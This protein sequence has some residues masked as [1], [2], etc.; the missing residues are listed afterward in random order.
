[1]K[2]DFGT[3]DTYI[4]SNIDTFQLEDGRTVWSMTFVE[5]MYGAIKNVD[6][7]LE[8]NKKSPKPFKDG[9]CSFPSSYRPEFDVTDELDEE[10]TNRFQQLIGVLRWYIELGRI[11]I[12]MEVI[13]SQHLCSP[14]EGHLNAVYNIFRYLQNNLSKN[15][16]MI[17]FY[18]DFYT[19]MRRYSREAQ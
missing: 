12:M 11:D 15:L 8:G 2:E 16:G 6:S 10:L 18:A 4:G 7:I 14:P 9:H 3:P 1:M 17:E 13:F 19:Q 5:Y